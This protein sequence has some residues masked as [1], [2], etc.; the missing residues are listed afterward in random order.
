MKSLLILLTV[1]SLNLEPYEGKILRV[2]DGDTLEQYQVS[3][4]KSQDFS[5]KPLMGSILR[6]IDGD[7]FVLQTSEGNLKIRMDGIDAPEM[8]Q[9]FGFEAKEFLNRY[10]HKNVRVLPN[11]VDKYGRT[12]GTLFVEGV[13]I[14]LLEVREGYAWHYKKY[15][16]DPEMTKAEEMARKE[17]KG[18]W[19]LMNALPPWEWRKMKSLLK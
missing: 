4:I 17:G 6:I 12:I 3:R 11:G 13:N 2:I 9:E 10:M 14:N 7:T 19:S 16:S 5:V 15:S 1:V 8:D 18:L